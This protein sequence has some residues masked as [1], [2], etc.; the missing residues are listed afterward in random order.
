M[1][2]DGLPPSLQI[3]SSKSSFLSPKFQPFPS[4]NNFLFIGK[5]PETLKSYSD[6]ENRSTMASVNSKF[7]WSV[8]QIG[9]RFF[10]RQNVSKLQ[11]NRSPML[12]IGARFLLCFSIKKSVFLQLLTHAQSPEL[13]QNYIKAITKVLYDLV[14]SISI[15]IKC[16][17]LLITCNNIHIFFGCV[18]MCI[19]FFI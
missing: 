1:S 18:L 19:P 7:N 14:S 4:K 11:K 5:L 10:T 17:S 9:A 16:S 3:S 12:K 2:F 8:C 13:N 6:V 15:T